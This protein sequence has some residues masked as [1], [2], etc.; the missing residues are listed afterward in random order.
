LERIT[1]CVQYRPAEGDCPCCRCC[2][3]TGTRDCD[4]E[5]PVPSWASPRSVP[6]LDRVRCAGGGALHATQFDS[7]DESG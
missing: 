4:V 6:T 1:V 2:V 5:V 3:A 7:G